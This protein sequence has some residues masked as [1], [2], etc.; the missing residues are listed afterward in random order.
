MTTPHNPIVPSREFVGTSRAGAYGDFVVEVDH[1]VGK[2]LRKIAALGIERN[3]IVIFTSD[4]GPVDRT[5]GYRARWV[6]GDT[7]IYGHDSNGPK[8]T[9]QVV[10]D[11]FPA[12]FV[13]HDLSKDIEETTDVSRNHPGMVKE[14]HALLKKYVREG[15]SN[16]G[17]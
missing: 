16:G 8:T 14:M 13:L 12:S 17:R 4:N 9:A 15:R 7:A 3:T 6:R 5:K 10:D 1:H 11:A 2:I